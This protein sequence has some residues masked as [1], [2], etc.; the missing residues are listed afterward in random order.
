MLSADRPNLLRC[1]MSCREW[2][3][4]GL[5]G[6]EPDLRLRMVDYMACRTVSLDELFLEATGAGVSQAVILAV[7]LDSRA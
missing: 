7:G 1:W 6:A 3:A 5:I 2:E 4:A